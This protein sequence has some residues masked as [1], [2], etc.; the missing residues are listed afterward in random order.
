MNFMG[1]QVILDLYPREWAKRSQACKLVS[2]FALHLTME[3][4][5]QQKSD[6]FVQIGELNA[7]ET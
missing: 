6:T 5:K 2:S 7:R 3:T 4:K 1:S